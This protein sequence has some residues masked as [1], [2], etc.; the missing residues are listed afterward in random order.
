[1]LGPLEETVVLFE[2]SDFYLCG[3]S[4]DNADLRMILRIGDTISMQV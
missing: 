4:V 3:V 2:K 1:M